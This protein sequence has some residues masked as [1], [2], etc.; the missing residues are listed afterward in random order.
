MINSIR[1]APFCPDANGER[2]GINLNRDSKRIEVNVKSPAVGEG[3]RYVRAS[4]LVLKDASFTVSDGDD[5]KHFVFDSTTAI[6]AT[7]PAVSA[8]N[9]GMKVKFTI[10]QLPGSGA[11]KVSPNAADKIMG[12]GFTPADDKDAEFT[13]AS[14][15]VGDTATFESDGVDGWFI[16]DVEGTI[17]RQS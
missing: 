15:R 17:D 10:K 9:K 13:A 14:D 16:S 11:H 1:S 5:G 4:Q 8:D 2:M 12:N 7:L 3:L 6:T